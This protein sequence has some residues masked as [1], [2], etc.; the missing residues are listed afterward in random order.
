ML[1]GKDKNIYNIID[2]TDYGHLCKH[3]HF[4]VHKSIGYFYVCNF[5][6]AKALMLSELFLSK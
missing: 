6:T 2:K 4:A 1:V 5:F 3:E